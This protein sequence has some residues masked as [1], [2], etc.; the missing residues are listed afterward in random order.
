MRQN[1]VR[2]TLFTVCATVVSATIFAQA[3]EAITL[4]TALQMA[5]K[6]NGAV[7]SANLDYQAAKANRKVAGSAFLPTL[8]PSYNRT[9]SRT[10]GGNFSGSQSSNSALVTFDWLLLD[11]GRRQATFRQA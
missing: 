7:R 1:L 8:T 10:N 9:E 4:D 6:N 3:T 11:N 2:L 5:K